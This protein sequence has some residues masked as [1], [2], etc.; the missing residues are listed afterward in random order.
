[1]RAATSHYKRPAAKIEFIAHRM[2]RIEK[3]NKLCQMGGKFENLKKSNRKTV[4]LRYLKDKNE[5]EKF[6]DVLRKLM[7]LHA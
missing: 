2:S 4:A 5:K 6:L 1:M 7:N 3:R